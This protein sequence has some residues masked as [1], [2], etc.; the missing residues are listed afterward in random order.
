MID[1]DT[2][3]GVSAMKIIK[4]NAQI[5]VSSMKTMASLGFEINSNNIYTK[6]ALIE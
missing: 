1:L 5:E 2:G 4:L 6:V 3:I